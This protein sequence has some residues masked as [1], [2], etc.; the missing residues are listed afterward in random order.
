MDFPK[1]SEVMAKR[2]EKN[3]D[4][5]KAEWYAIECQVRSQ[6]RQ[7]KTQFEVFTWVHNGMP[8]AVRRQLQVEVADA[9][10]AAG[11]ISEDDNQYAKVRVSQG[12][13]PSHNTLYALYVK[14][15]L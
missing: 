9:I 15:K 12:W 13:Y 14:V 8:K 2:R 11:W 7:G 1:R 3:R 10:A 6:L 5:Y 4:D